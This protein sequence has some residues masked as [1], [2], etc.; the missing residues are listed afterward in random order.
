MSNISSL[1]SMP[2]LFFIAILLITNQF[3]I[4]LYTNNIWFGKFKSYDGMQRAHIGEV[5]RLG[6][7]AIYL[8]LLGFYFFYEGDKFSNGQEFL[9]LISPFIIISVVED[10]F[11][12]VSIK[13][14][15]LVMTVVVLSLTI[16]WIDSFPAVKHIPILS[17]LLEFKA[18]SVLF[19]TLA[20]IVLM[21]GA[22]FIDGMNGLAGLFFLGAFL[23][24]FSLS[25]IA[26]DNQAFIELIPWLVALLIFLLFN[27]P[28]G[29][30]FLGD[31]GAYL[32]AVF[33]GGWL[34]NF[35]ATHNQFSSWNAAFILIYPTI[36]ALFSVTRKAI[37]GNSPFHPDRNH[38]HIRIF[39]T[40]KRSTKNSTYA[41]NA[42][43]LFLAIFW[44]TPPLVLPYVYNSQVSIIFSIIIFSLVYVLLYLWISSIKHK[45]S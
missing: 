13:L 20:F 12:N 1:G 35:F 34:I 27:F 31:S 43:T 26:N 16:F 19:F 29:K 15:L 9:I 6:G 44:I 37:K 14:R 40:I 28:L 2:L 24:C 11:H 7:F 4:S 18:F 23:S 39:D 21:N 30:I 32:L 41:N 33:L 25:Y 3:F 38:L 45:N 8:S 5:P 42:T 10:I 22:N 17:N 36:E